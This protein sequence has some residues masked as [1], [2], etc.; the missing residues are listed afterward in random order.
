VAIRLPIRN[1]GINI[2]NNSIPHNV[3]LQ[4]KMRQ[5]L[6]DF[7][8]KQVENLMSHETDNILLSPADQLRKIEINLYM[9]GID[10][11]NTALKEFRQQQIQVLA[12]EQKLINDLSDE[13]FQKMFFDDDGILKTT[14][15][16]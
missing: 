2:L 1:I 7:R 16:K 5:E 3:E 9:D 11:S 10:V 12:A 14:P 8:Q 6:R 13:D 4:S 15:P